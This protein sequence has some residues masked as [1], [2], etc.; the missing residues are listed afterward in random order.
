MDQR[1]SASSGAVAGPVPGLPGD[2]P[3]R[4]ILFVVAGVAIF[5][6]QDVIIKWL[7]GDF[8]LYQ[9]MVLRSISA[10]PLFVVLIWL[11]GRK[12]SAVMS[13]RWPAL[14]GRGVLNACAYTAFYAALASLP[15]AT[16]I[17]LFFTAPFFITI[18]SALVL[19]ERVGPYRWAAV[20]VGFI[21]VVMVMRPSGEVLDPVALLPIIASFFY[22][23][24]Q[25]WARSLGPYESAGVM[26][27]YSIL[28]FFVVSGAMALVA[29]DGNITETGNASLDFL[30]RGWQVMSPLDLTLMLLT[31]VISTIALTLLTQGYRLAPA[32]T[33]APFEY[34]MLLW[35]ML[36]GFLVFGERPDPASL[37][38]TLIIIGSGL[39]ILFRERVTGTPTLFRR[40]GW[41]RL[42]DIG[43]LPGRRRSRRPADVATDETSRH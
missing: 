6:F 27:F 16:A 31:G 3:M 37:P 12:P 22:A 21:G 2:N 34:S 1:V 39:F 30:I 28:V 11:E 24:M 20:V 17:T 9:V 15:I 38:G 13:P 23:L 36:L 32:S 7:S 42:R 29:G 35:G 18:L 14:C 41:R 4:A 19:K 8:P 25:I 10:L 40:G 5:A 26:S 43:L 33:V